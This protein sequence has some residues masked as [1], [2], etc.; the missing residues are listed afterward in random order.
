MVIKGAGGLRKVRWSRPGTGK[1]GGVRVIYFARLPR[2]EVALLI[3][4]AKAKFDKL[5][6]DFLLKLKE[7]LYGQEN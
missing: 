4:Y 1:R 5:P 3:V 2:G 6:T 7:K